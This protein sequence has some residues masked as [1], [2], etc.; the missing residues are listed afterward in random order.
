[1]HEEVR[2]YEGRDCE[3]RAFAR[4]GPDG[5]REITR[6][7]P[8]LA[9]LE[10]EPTSAGSLSLALLTLLNLD[11]ELRF[12]VQSVFKNITNYSP[13]FHPFSAVIV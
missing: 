1:M 13:S 6:R 10:F 5:K 8:L 11:L 2:R 7:S 4:T 9:I 12:K 3:A